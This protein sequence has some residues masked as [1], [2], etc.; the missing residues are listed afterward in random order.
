V[1]SVRASDHD[2]GE[3]DQ[4][5]RSLNLTDL[6]VFRE[7]EESMSPA[8]SASDIVYIMNTHPR[9]L[10]N[11]QYFY[12]TNAQYEFHIARVGTDNSK[13]ADTNDNIVIRFEFGAPNANNQQAITMTT[14]RDGVST[15]TTADNSG[16]PMLTTAAYTSTTTLPG[17]QATGGNTT[18][19]VSPPNIINT[20][21]NGSA[22]TL[23]VGHRADPFFFNVTGFFQM[24]LAAAFAATTNDYVN[25]AVDNF[26][27][28]GSGGFAPP[29]GPDFTQ[30]YNVSSIVARFPISWLQTSANETVFDN[31]E[32]INV[33]Q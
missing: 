15:V 1:H 21:V 24:R 5:G 3:M 28:L 13:P 14:I 17:G 29:V 16:N 11:Q 22:F 2:D 27:G 8:G 10:P 9:S 7:D 33:A 20:T 23:F 18:A 31:W 6:F 30:N 32:V 26:T 19:G 25:A 4:K 12:S